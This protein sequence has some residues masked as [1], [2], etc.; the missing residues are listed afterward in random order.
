MLVIGRNCSISFQAAYLFGGSKINGFTFL[1]KLC[2]SVIAL[3]FVLEYDI[4]C[5]FIIL[6]NDVM[7]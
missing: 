6:S 3:R 5:S 2:F 1:A 4:L 7:S